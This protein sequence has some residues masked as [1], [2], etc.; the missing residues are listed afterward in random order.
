[1]LNGDIWLS[2]KRPNRTLV[3]TNLCKTADLVSM[4]RILYVWNYREWGGAQIYFLSLMREALRGK[5]W[6]EGGGQCQVSVIVPEDS[7]ARLLGYLDELG[8]E[9]EF[10]EAAPPVMNPVGAVNKLRY[11]AKMFASENRLVGRV[12][13]ALDAGEAGYHPVREDAATPPNH[14]GEFQAIVHID[15]GFWQSYRALARLCRRADVFVTQHTALV[16]P[17]GVRGLAWR[18]NGKSISRF[19]TFHPL[20][21]N[22]SAAESLRPFLSPEK[23]DE[24]TVTYSGFE[25]DEFADLEVS[26]AAICERYS[27]PQNMP[28]IMA[29]GQFIERKGCWVL[30]ESL[31]KL[32]KDGEEFQ[33]VWLGTSPLGTDDVGRVDAYGLGASFRFMSAEEIGPTRRDLLS[34]L[35]CADIFVLPSFREGLP[36]ALVEAMALGLPCI[37]SNV[38]AIPEAIVDDASGLLVEAG[39]ADALAAAIKTLIHDDETRRMFSTAAKAI[40]YEK[41]DQ[42]ATARETLKIYAERAETRP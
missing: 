39:D 1:M 6:A 41:F 37:A 42:Q 9:V 2:L 18:W 29:V 27:L 17:G 36:I 35:G 7:D 11:R 13:K 22:R 16:D 12:L 31:K 19:R 25:P 34:L 8:V 23:Y 32:R 40:A 5:Q 4:R 33:F 14:G 3:D 15:L 10:S 30:L 28:L 21:S 20:A 38:G 24:M 26:K